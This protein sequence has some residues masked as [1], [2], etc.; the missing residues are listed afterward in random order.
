MQK[1]GVID[2][3]TN[4]MRMLVSQVQDG[5]ILNSYKLLQTSR[6]GEGINQG[7][8]PPQV[9][10]KNIDYLRLFKESALDDGVED[11]IVFGTSALRDAKNSGGFIQRV[12]RELNLSIK[13]LSGEEEAMIGF[14]GATYDLPKEAI[15]IDIGGGSTEF[16]VGNKEGEFSQVLSLK[17]GAVRFTEAYVKHDPI[18]KEEIMA[19]EK[20]IANSIKE[21]GPDFYPIGIKDIIGIGGT[22]TSLVAIKQ[23]LETYD[24]NKVHGSVLYRDDL[25]TFLERTL[26][27]TL[28]ERKRI[29]G[30]HPGRA[31]II[32]A[33]SLIL[34][35]IMTYLKMEKLLVSDRDN[36][37]GMLYCY[38]SK[39][40]L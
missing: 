15:I 24:T 2:I 12:N 11:I 8:I 36:L 28:A 35:G 3:G 37:E 21:I 34:K 31:D 14:R 29:K 25:K 13:V 40:D 19:I 33:G 1:I 18:M 20:A 9:I 26:P 10:D 6:L 4:S 30:L 17:M 7:K 5:R 32:I 16:I 23:N 38:L 39:K 22:I 27:L